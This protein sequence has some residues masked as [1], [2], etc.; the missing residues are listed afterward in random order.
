MKNTLTQKTFLPFFFTLS[1]LFLT[2]W[3]AQVC[4]QTSCTYTINMFD[5]FGDGWNNGKLIVVSNGDTTEH[6][7]TTG[8]TGFSTFTV[9][10]G[11]LIQVFWVPGSFPTEVAFQILNNDLDVVYD[12]GPT[13]SPAPPVGLNYE[14]IAVCPKCKIPNPSLVFIFNITDSSAHVNWLDSPG[15]DYYQVT[16]GPAGFPP[17]TGITFDTT[18]SSADLYGL[19]PGVAYDVYINA[20]CGPDS[21]SKAIGPYTFVTKFTPS[22]PNDSCQFTLQL[23]DSFGDGW[24]GSFL[25]LDVNG[26]K[27]DYGMPAGDSLTYVVNVPANTPV[28]FIYTAGSFQSEVSYK[29]LDQDGKVI[30]QDGP[31]PATGEVFS[32]IACPTCPGPLDAWMSDVNANNAVVSW[33]KFPGFD[34]VGNYIVEYGPMGFTI[35]TGQRDTVPGTANSRTLVGLQENTWYNVY[36]WRSCSDSSYSQLTGPLFFKTL[37]LMDIGV[38]TIIHPNPQDKCYFSTADSVTIGITNYGQLPQTLFEFNYSVN[39]IPAGV[40]L[41]Q[42]G[43][44]TGVVGNDSTNFISFE[45]TFDFSKPGTY[46]IKAWTVLEGDSNPANDT[47]TYV[48]QTA[49]P[50]PLSEDF[51][52][53]AVPSSWV[54]DGII[55]APNAHNNPTYVI[56]DNLFSGDKTF[57]LTTHRVG[58]IEPGDSLTFDY[59][60]V[61]WSTGNTPTPIGGNKLEVLIST[62][63]EESW[64]LVHLVDSTNHVESTDFA[65]VVVDLTPFADSAIHVRFLGTWA[66]GDFY[67]DLDNINI[68]G[69][70]P[71]LVILPSAKPTIAGGATGSA[72]VSVFSGVAP[73]EFVWTNAMGDTLSTAATADSLEA[74]DYFVY[75][76]D[77]NGCTDSRVVTIEV[78]TSANEVVIAPD[79]VLYP[80]P[81]SGMVNVRLEQQQVQPALLRLISI[82][83]QV[84][85]EKS[86]PAARSSTEELDL[87]FLP[88]G[89][90][91]VQVV[92]GEGSWHTRLVVQR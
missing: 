8:M 46:I 20:V 77:A 57:T 37:W 40:T 88:P 29:I 33:V 69:C 17:G 55:Y 71:S 38:S 43:L 83:G 56:A 27:T 49:L 25:T 2:G 58:P 32:T 84:L 73:Y 30:F 67:L 24:N 28:H 16:Y 12:S 80:N 39:G 51:E 44:Y 34:N 72:S 19:N 14:G 68:A 61:N 54:H 31:N 45:T 26:V 92:I 11:T 90:Y 22:S 1:L 42:D 78:F 9:I 23:F 75:V 60:F 53:N 3:T 7:L 50:K 74:G 6:T 4:G 18:S 21:V 79:I 64:Q 47:F 10:Q 52:D 86:L 48:F 65:K 35:G 13:G 81:A 70:P 89:L 85:L 59:R 66:Q 62:D 5:S 63:C 87:S 91:V 41:P 76:M 82:Q 36:I 15:A